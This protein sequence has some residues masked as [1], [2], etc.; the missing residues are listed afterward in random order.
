MAHVQGSVS[1]NSFLNLLSCVQDVWQI[2]DAFLV[3]SDYKQN[4]PQLPAG[5]RALFRFPRLTCPCGC[6]CWIHIQQEEWWPAGMHK[7]KSSGWIRVKPEYFLSLSRFNSWSA[8][9]A[10]MCLRKLSTQSTIQYRDIPWMK[11]VMFLP[12]DSSNYR[13]PVVLI[14]AYPPQ[15][16]SKCSSDCYWRPRWSYPEWV[17]GYTPCFWR[18]QGQML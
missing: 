18:V 16:V 6:S 9:L 7:G 3:H 11:T 2:S 14:V 13:Y 5:I 12:H 4:T 10:F 1:D 15:K 17:S 8:S